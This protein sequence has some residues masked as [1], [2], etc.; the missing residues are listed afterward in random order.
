VHTITR[1]LDDDT[2]VVSSLAGEIRIEKTEVPTGREDRYG[3]DITRWGYVFDAV[4][5][6]ALLGFPGFYGP[7]LSFRNLR[8]AKRAAEIILG[9]LAGP[10]R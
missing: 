10:C 6:E 4:S 5:R 3:N 2:W 1:K 9:R 8:D 7:S